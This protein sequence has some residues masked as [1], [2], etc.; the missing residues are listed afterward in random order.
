MAPGIQWSEERL[1]DEYTLANTEDGQ[2]NT[3]NDFMCTLFDGL[4]EHNEW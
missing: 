3:M 1:E 4:G 2:L